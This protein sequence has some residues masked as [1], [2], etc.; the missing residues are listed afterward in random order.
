[1]FCNIF[2][3]SEFCPERSRTN[4]IQKLLPNGSLALNWG[5]KS[6]FP[7]QRC[8][9]WSLPQCW[10]GAASMPSTAGGPGSAPPLC[11]R[12]GVRAQ[13]GVLW[14]SSGWHLSPGSPE[15]EPVG[16][17]LSVCLPVYLLSIY[18]E[19]DTIRNRVACFWRLGGPQICHLQAE[20]P[21]ELVVWLQSEVK[22]RKRP[23][24]SSKTV[25]QR[26]NSFLLCLLFYSGFQQIG[27]GPPT[28]EE[29]YLF[30]S[31]QQIK[32]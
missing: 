11:C 22:G 30:Y 26:E 31:V 23:W 12:T 14:G 24:L 16:E 3:V 4:C 32:R 20:D 10:W 13:G 18:W 9:M 15:K 1:M 8:G 19:K 27:W 6:M 7:P 29:D 28:L 21:G 2:D 5:T 25:K 17:C